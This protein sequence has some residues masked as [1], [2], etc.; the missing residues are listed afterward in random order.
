MKFKIKLETIKNYLSKLSTSIQTISSQ[1]EF[2]GILITIDENSITFEGRNDYIDTKITEN[3]QANIKIDKIGKILVKANILNEIIQRMEGDFVEFNQIDSNVL[4]INDKDSNY[5]INLL[6][7]EKYEK[8]KFISEFD[9]TLI[10]KATNFKRLIS[11]TIFAGNEYHNKFIFQGLNLVNENGNLISNVCDG[12]RVASY[13][14]QISS[15]ETINK[16][17]PLKVVKE[18]NKILPINCEYKFLFKLNKGIVVADNMI[19][20]FG[21]IEG[22]FPKFDKFFN[23]DSY[24]KKMTIDKDTFNKM[25]E[26]ITIISTNKIESRIGLKISKNNFIIES[27]EHEIGSAK[28][29]VTDYEYEG[30]EIDISLASKLLHDGLKNIETEKVYMFFTNNQNSILITDGKN[31]EFFYLL[32][33]MI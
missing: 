5:K 20:Q 14:K 8:A 32:S 3:N 19:A 10:I 7:S 22:T 30:D 16:I 26:R 31:N 27:K 15:N 1:M 29:N 11:N 12:I 18:L 17:I 21:L 9:E 4:T 2:T 24:N 13:R 33:P 25:I 28:I 6:N 23:K